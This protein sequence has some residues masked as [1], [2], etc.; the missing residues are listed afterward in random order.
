MV[1]IFGIIIF[2]LY[3]ISIIST[4][5]NMFAFDKTN[6]IVYLITG[7]FIVSVVT[8]IMSKANLQIDNKELI[9]IIQ[10]STQIIFIPLNALITLPII[11]NIMS[12]YKAKAITEDKLKR[13]ILLIVIIYIIFF[14]FEKKYITNFQTGV[15]S[16]INR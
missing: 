16:N 2:A 5:Q 8:V 13:R 15:L 11:A 10:N 3:V 4:Y 7:F 6:R 12:K 14:I 1:F 9:K